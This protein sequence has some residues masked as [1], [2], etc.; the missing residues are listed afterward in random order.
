MA[1]PGEP[2]ADPI[3]SAIN[4][5]VRAYDTAAAAIDGIADPLQVFKY[6]TAL[7]VELA[8]TVEENALR[9]A[10]AAADVGRASR[11]SL[12]ELA[13]RLSTADHP[14]SKARVAQLLRRAGAAEAPDDEGYSRR[15]SSLKPGRS[16]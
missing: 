1:E 10:A 3:A 15:H 2:P 4:D 8:R 12:A 7:G 6:A 13:Q 5:L 11:L 9:R 16:E 14:V